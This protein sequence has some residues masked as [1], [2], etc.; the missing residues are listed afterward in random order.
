MGL[1]RRK[2][3]EHCKRPTAPVEEGLGHRCIHAA[4]GNAGASPDL[5]TAQHANEATLQ[6]PAIFLRISSHSGVASRRQLV[7]KRPQSWVGCRQ[8]GVSEKNDSRRPQQE[9]PVQ[10]RCSQACQDQ[11]AG[12]PV[13]EGIW[14]GSQDLPKRLPQMLACR[15][16]PH[17][18]LSPGTAHAIMTGC[19]LES[20][21]EVVVAVLDVGSMPCGRVVVLVVGS[22]AGL[23]RRAVHK[24]V[25]SRTTAGH[26]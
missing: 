22:S 17:Q 11:A 24:G 9:Q 20:V 13:G 15:R 5:G 16:R 6:E 8:A 23:A 10:V 2:F 4:V 18:G 12:T 7:Q 1:R 26:W 21:V 19:M 14:R 3:R 25:G